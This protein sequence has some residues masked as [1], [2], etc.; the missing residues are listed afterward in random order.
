MA[1][2]DKCKIDAC[3]NFVTYLG[4]ACDHHRY[5]KYQYGSYYEEP[6]KITRNEFFLSR[7]SPQNENGCILWVG[8]L[9]QAGYGVIWDGR[10]W[11]KAHRFSYKI[12]NSSIPKGMC[13]LHKCDVR[14]CVNIEH[15]FLGTQEEN[16]KDM[17]TKNRANFGF[18]KLNE[19][20]VKIIKKLIKENI[21][22]KIIACQFSV[23]RDTI[24]HIRNGKNWRNV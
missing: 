2:G 14:N 16:I 22:D 21:H 5:L 13:I 12:Y 9:D 4:R 24:R 20:Q 23:H 6:K 8:H 7:I 11:T 3:N 10:R 17:I 18:R 1:R 15:L 19:D